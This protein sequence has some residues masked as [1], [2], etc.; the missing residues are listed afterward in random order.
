LLFVTEATPHDLLIDWYY[1]NL[2]LDEGSEMKRIHRLVLIGQWTEAARR[3]TNALP[4]SAESAIV[5]ER[6]AKA[7]KVRESNNFEANTF[8]EYWK[9]MC[10]YDLL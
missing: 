3:L 6:L 8:P 10:R 5:V 1:K 4:G 2:S 9:E 7:K